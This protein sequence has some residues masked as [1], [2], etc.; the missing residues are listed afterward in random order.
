MKRIDKSISKNYFPVRLQL[1][2]LEELERTLLEKGSGKVALQ[3]GDYSFDSVADLE[4]NRTGEIFHDVEIKKTDPYF[5]IELKR[6][7][8]RV[9]VGSSEPESAGIFYNLNQLLERR[10]RSLGFLYSYYFIWILNAI[11][12]LSNLLTAKKLIPLAVAN[13][14]SVFGLTLVIWILWVRLWHYSTIVAKHKRDVTGFFA[15]NRDSLIVAIVAAIIGALL[16]VVGTLL[17]SKYS[18]R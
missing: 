9:Y 14:L 16:G 12:L 2:D 8:A 11:L 18:S 10:Q 4:S 6:L 15:R 17:I 1:D 13:G 5:S 3:V 7:W